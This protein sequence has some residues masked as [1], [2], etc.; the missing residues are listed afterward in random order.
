MRKARNILSAPQEIAKAIFFG[1]GMSFPSS[2]KTSGR[3]VDSDSNAEKL[4]IILL[5]EIKLFNSFNCCLF[6]FFMI[7]SELVE[8]SKNYNSENCNEFEYES[9]NSKTEHI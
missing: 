4:V 8:E 9:H 6:V 3:C 2:Q 1:E 5:F 7:N